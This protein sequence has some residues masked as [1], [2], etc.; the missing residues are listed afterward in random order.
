MR[1]TTISVRYENMLHKLREEVT[2]TQQTCNHVKII[3]DVD[4]V[5][6]FEQV[7]RQLLLSWK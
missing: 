7:Q 6:L 4:S 3:G 2:G 5:V 1:L